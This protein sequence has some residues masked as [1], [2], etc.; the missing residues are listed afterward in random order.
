MTARAL[1][2]LIAVGVALACAGG[3]RAQTYPAKPVTMIVPFPAGG[4]S[5]IL[6]RIV[7]EHMRGSLGQPVVIENVGGAGGTIGTTRVARSA[8]DGYTIGF[9][10]WTSHVGAGAL[11][12]LTFDLLK[13]LAPVARLTLARLWIIGRPELPAKDLKQLIAWLKANPGKATAGTI[14]AG[15][16]TQLCLIDFQNNTG[17]QF[18]LVPYRG[19]APIMQDL[20][21]GQIDLTCPE[22]GQT[23]ALYR[24]G[25]VRP[26]AVMGTTRWFAAPDVPTTDEA[27]A[28]GLHMTFWYGL[29]APAGTPR[30]M[31]AKLNAAVN[32]A[33]DDPAVRQ[34][35]T[36]QGH[37]FPA[38]E[39]R[40]P[41]ALGAHHKAEI[42][43]WWPIIKAAGIKL[44]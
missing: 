41:E 14:G 1:S 15:S 10:Q 27:G 9:G 30:E 16:G 31:I 39:Q 35:L 25:K 6:A 18:Q 44:Q 43:K 32:A 24:A 22:A 23:L 36:E 29:W 4:G 42:E 21:A 13:D 5:D 17:T 34:R 7:A 20:L 19:A 12:P 26:Y 38:R 28:P 3:A 37:D 2:F 40:S 11:Y 33:F 8:P